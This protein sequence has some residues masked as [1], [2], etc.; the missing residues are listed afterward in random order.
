MRIAKTPIKMPERHRVIP[1]ETDGAS[2]LE[3]RARAYP[4]GMRLGLHVHPAAQLLF[5]SAGMMQ[6]TTPRG[7]WLVPP[8]RA[9]W[10]PPGIE[11]AVDM[12]TDVEMRSLYIAPRRL[13][14]H[15]DAARLAHEFVVAVGALL[16]EAVLALF[17]E[18]AVA[19]RI[20]ILAELVLIE[21]AE[22]EDATTFMPMPCDP[23][24]R[25][26]AELVL[27]DPRGSR[28]LDDIAAAAGV[29]PR[30]VTRIFPVET[31]LTFKEWRQR[32]RIMAAMEAFGGGER[33]VKRV[34]VRLGFSSLAAFGHA[35]RQVTGMTPSAFLARCSQPMGGAMSGGGSP[36]GP[37]K[38]RLP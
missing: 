1:V 3:A 31:N 5:A 25:R 32:A 7:R 18:A 6:V 22:A 26:V 16:R 15:P 34:S 8:Q 21:L 23:R 27:A 28:G 30:T 9:V 11:H 4:L 12:L 17:T 10:L 13:A 33:L 20:A 29:S 14:A 2:G 37:P 36:A 19:R 38:T 35:F 24:A